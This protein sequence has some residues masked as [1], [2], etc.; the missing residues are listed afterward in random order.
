MHGLPMA[1]LHADRCSLVWRRGPAADGAV[2]GVAAINKCAEVQELSV[3]S[4][5]GRWRWQL[6]E[7]NAQTPGLRI[8]ADQLRLRL[9]PRRALLWMGEGPGQP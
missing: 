4:P 7:R 9:G 8:E 6:L 5:R 3:P 2:M 1:V